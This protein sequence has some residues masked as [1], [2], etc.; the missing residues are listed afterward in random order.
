[1]DELNETI[2]LINNYQ[3]QLQIIN[4]NAHINRKAIEGFAFNDELIKKSDDDRQVEEANHITTD[5][6]DSASSQSE[7]EEIP[8]DSDNEHFED[9]DEDGLFKIV[10]KEIIFLFFIL[11]FWILSKKSQTICVNKSLFITK[12]KP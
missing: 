11:N 5:S 4:P 3:K 6:D 7:S 2:D 1:M 9:Y 8:S 12:K 10:S